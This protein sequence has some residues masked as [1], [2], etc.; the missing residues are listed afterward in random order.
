MLATL[1]LGSALAPVLIEL[2]GPEA[3]LVITGILLPVLALLT[4]PRL[5]AIDGGASAPEAT[6]LL[7]GVPLLAALPEPVLERLAREAAPASFTAGTTIVR[8]GDPG[9]RFYVVSSGT[10]GIL[11][12]ELGPGEAFGEIALLRDVPRTAT[13]TAVTD[14]SVV[15]LERAPFVAAVT[16]HAPSAAAADTLIAARLGSL[17]ARGSASV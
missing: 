2:V 7:R 4:R 6:G 9:D 8:E 3:S 17:S 12:R 14:V 16:G 1:G 10:V 13:A 15:T 11:G 5:R